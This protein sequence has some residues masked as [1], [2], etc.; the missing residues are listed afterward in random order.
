MAS[1]LFE[2]EDAGSFEAIHAP[3]DLEV[4]ESVDRDVDG[5]AGIV[6]HFFGDHFR[7]NADVLAVGHVGAEVEVFEVDAE[8]PGAFLGV[9]DGG[10]DLQLGVEHGDSGRAGVT[11]VVESVATGGHADAMGIVF[12]WADVA[13]V[14]GVR[15]VAVGGDVGFLDKKDGAGPGNALGGEAVLADA[16]F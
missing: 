9:G 8:I 4:D 13:D 11:G 2:G 6:P 14:V 7:E 15:N 1:K 3:S 10:V 5:V 12:L 16:K